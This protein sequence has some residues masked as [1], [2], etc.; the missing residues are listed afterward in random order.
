[1][2][3]AKGRTMNKKHGSLN[4]VLSLLIMSLLFFWGGCT[5]G[6]PWYKGP[7]GNICPQDKLCTI[8]KGID[9]DSAK[10]NAVSGLSKLII[11]KISQNNILRWQSVG[12]YSEKD[13]VFKLQDILEK[14]VNSIFIDKKHDDQTRKVS[15]VLAFLDKKEIEMV[16]LDAINMIDKK[17]KN[18]F[19]SDKIGSTIKTK[20]LYFEREMWNDSYEFL[21][22]KRIPSSIEANVIFRRDL[23]RIR[24]GAA[25]CSSCSSCSF[26]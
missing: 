25:G 13:V 26:F 6:P 1:M 14:P 7:L 12:G 2:A 11:S 8:G 23:Q 16:L 15:F 18:E 21:G 20:E 19:E 10:K 3:A 24:R 5:K 17:M 22:G 4:N 9:V